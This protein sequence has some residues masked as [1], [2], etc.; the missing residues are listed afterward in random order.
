MLAGG[1]RTG[2]SLWFPPPDRFEGGRRPPCNYRPSKAFQHLSEIG[3]ENNVT[4]VLTFFKI[5]FSYGFWKYS[6][7]QDL[8]TKY[9][10]L[11]SKTLVE[12]RKNAKRSKLLAI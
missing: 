12:E 4:L 9:R 10:I 11:T 3:G 7:N 1:H 2:G 5:Y 8:D 6:R